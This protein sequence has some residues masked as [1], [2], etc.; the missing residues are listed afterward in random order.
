MTER[1]SSG[2]SARVRGV[3]G[4]KRYLRENEQK[5]G[6]VN[7]RI[8]WILALELNGNKHHVILP[9]HLIVK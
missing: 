4:E 5:L 9:H 3:Y 8:T 2:N 1:K 7:F 6:T